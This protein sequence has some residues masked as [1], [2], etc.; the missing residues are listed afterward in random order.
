MKKRIV[1]LLLIAIAAIGCL[2]GSAS[3]GIAQPKVNLI[4]DGA[5]YAAIDANGEEAIKMPENPTKDGYI[6]DGWYLDNDMWQTPFD[7]SSLL[8]KPL[9]SNI[10]VYAKWKSNGVRVESVTLDK[11]ELFMLIGNEQILTATILPSN[12]SEQGVLWHSSDPSV[13][14]VENGVTKAIGQGKAT[15]TVTTIDGGKTASL[16]IV[17][18][19]DESFFKVFIVDGNEITGLTNY[20]KT[21]TEIT[22]PSEIDGVKITS[23]GA[24]SFYDC[25]GLTSVTI[26]DSATLPS[27]HPQNN[28]R[29]L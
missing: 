3:C 25:G 5:V 10:S 12:A 21:L 28:Y 16:E 1:T 7:E 26:S 18:A 23:I 13:A 17:V 6:F 4:V 24:Y 8:G 22:I 9:S 20:G 27:L 29:T 14:T 15:I 11:S 19:E 2:F